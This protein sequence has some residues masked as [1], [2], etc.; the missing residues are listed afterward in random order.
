MSVVYM[1]STC[2]SHLLLFDDVDEP[3]EPLCDPL[4]LDGAGRDNGPGSVLQLHQVEFFGDLTG[5][6]GARLVL[7]VGKHQQGAVLQLVLL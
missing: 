7:L 1:F 4:P 6:H 2:G 3:V 5:T